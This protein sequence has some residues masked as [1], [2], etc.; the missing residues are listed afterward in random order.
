MELGGH[1]I[2]GLKSELAQLRLFLCNAESTL[3]KAEERIDKVDVLEVC[4]S[5]NE[6]GSF[7]CLG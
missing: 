5:N 4:D 6:N 3:A 2:E 7:Q 1:P